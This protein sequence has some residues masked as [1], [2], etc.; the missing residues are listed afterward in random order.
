MSRDWGRLSQL[1]LLL[2]LIIV[3]LYN[4][5]V[6]PQLD[7]AEANLFLKNSVAFLNIGL[8][9]FVISSL[10]VRFLFPAVSAEGR[11]FWILKGS[12]VS[13]HRVL[14]VKYFF[15]LT[16]MLLLGLFL[17][18]MTNRLLG[19]GFFISAV[20]TVSIFFITLAVTSLSIGLGVL[21]ADL[22]ES[23]P[24]A[25]FSGF[26]GLMTMLYSGLTVA[27]II[28]LEAFPVYRIVTANYFGRPLNHTDLFIITTL[29][30]CSFGLALF[31]A[32]YP[33]KLGLKRIMDLQ[34]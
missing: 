23:D 20:S 24:S 26:G 18:I 10:G 19:L 3:Y 33:L 13:L 7:S 11:A 14:W 28:I 4:F 16:P 17:V 2:A 34:I 5:S 12:P 22:K 25:V 29:I 6:L 9:G 15:Y 32:I 27:G 8:A 31:A 30:M 21:Y 1:L